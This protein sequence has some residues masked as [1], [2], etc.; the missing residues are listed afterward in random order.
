MHRQV[1]NRWTD[2]WTD[3][4]HGQTQMGGWMNKWEDRSVDGQVSEWLDGRMDG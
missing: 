1:V 2:G 4:V 3:I